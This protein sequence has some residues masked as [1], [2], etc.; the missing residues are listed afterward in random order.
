MGVVVSHVPNKQENL[1]LQKIKKEC[2][3]W[4]CRREEMK[5]EGSC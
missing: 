2:G 3:R 4:A 5:F 1:D